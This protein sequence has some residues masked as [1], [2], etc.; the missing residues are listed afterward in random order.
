MRTLVLEMRAPEVQSPTCEPLCRNAT[1]NI[2][3]C[4]ENSSKG[5]E[6]QIDERAQSAY[7]CVEMRRKSQTVV[8]KREGGRGWGEKDRTYVV[9]RCQNHS[10]EPSCGNETQNADR[11]A[12]NAGSDR[13]G[14]RQMG[15]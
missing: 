3:R 10:C 9:K 1:Q 11:C 7:R 8:R 12:D 15:G 4:A 2:Y 13:G 6:G 14:S 5:K